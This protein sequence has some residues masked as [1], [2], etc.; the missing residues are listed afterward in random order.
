VEV[1]GGGGVTSHPDLSNLDFA[2][3]GHTGFEAEGA[4]AAA[5]LWDASSELG[6]IEPKAS[7]KI[8][9]NIINPI[10]YQVTT[11][12][13]TATIEINLLN[14]QAIEIEY[15]GA[16]DSTS[17]VG[18]FII[19][20]VV[21]AD[22]YSGTTADVRFL[23]YVGRV[24]CSSRTLLLRNSTGNIFME[25]HAVHR[26]NTVAN[27]LIAD[28]ILHGL[29]LNSQPGI[30]KVTLRAP[31]SRVFNAGTTIIVRRRIQ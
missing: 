7:K 3:S 30:N 31:V 19:N 16:T 18:T 25:T 1:V 2:S 24:F 14:E 6:Y 26:Y 12:V 27:P 22:Y 17:T 10:I 20:D 28:R 21:S 13:D 5:A 4:A 15:T 8:R 23:F 9:P 11:D 29:L